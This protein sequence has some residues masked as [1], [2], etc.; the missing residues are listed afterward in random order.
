MVTSSER[1][2]SCKH[3]SRSLVL[4]AS[5]NCLDAGAWFLKEQV[6]TFG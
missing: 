6:E 2:E 3:E 1:T 4:T 5:D